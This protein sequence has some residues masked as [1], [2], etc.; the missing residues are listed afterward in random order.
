MSDRVY[1]NYWQ[2]KQLPKETPHFPL[3]R[4]WRTDGLCDIERVY[5]EAVKPAQRLLD[6][7][8]GDLR[9]RQKLL[10]AG[11]TGEYHTQ[12]IGGEHEYTYSS[13]DEVDDGYDAVLC[14][15][16]VEHLPLGEG[17][18]LI[19]RLVELLNPGGS[20]VIQTPNARCIRSPLAWDMSHLHMY[21][22]PD[23]WAYLRGMGLDAR[24]YRVWFTGPRFSPAGWLRATAARFVITQ[25]LGCDYA[26]NVA[27][28]AR[29]P[30]GGPASNGQSG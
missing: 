12:D 11:Y 29:K 24:G 4:W 20:L 10:V 27:I 9:I 25:L 8:A 1:L 28:V 2:R 17:L 23:L 30:A 15:D 22:L 13:L 19:G 14:L 6:V 16:V 5:F 21:N 18:K 26:D 7:G 3:R